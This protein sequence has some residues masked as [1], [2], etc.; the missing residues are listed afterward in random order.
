MK[1]LIASEISVKNEEILVVRG[2][3]SE[4]L[5]SLP[6]DSSVT[7]WDESAVVSLGVAADLDNGVYEALEAL[8]EALENVDIVLLSR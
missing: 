3:T 1:K 8:G 7:Q 6:D 4:F 2:V 5:D